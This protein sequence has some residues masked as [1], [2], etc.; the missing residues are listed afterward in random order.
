MVR[1]SA[2]GGTSVCAP[3]QACPDLA[4]RAP[5]CA[6]CVTPSSRAKVEEVGLLP[7]WAGGSPAP[8]VFRQR[9]WVAGAGGGVRPPTPGRALGRENRARSPA[10]LPD[11]DIGLTPSILPGGCGKWSYS[12]VPRTWEEHSV[13]PQEQE[14][15][16]AHTQP[17]RSLRFPR[18][19]C[20]HLGRDG[21][22]RPG[23]RAPGPRLPRGATGPLGRRR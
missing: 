12:V 14:S 18:G 6:L 10:Q 16:G 9:E 11:P 23:V 1:T 3:P 17:N 7:G 4:R 8:V 21:R 19:P 2:R 20:P 13:L 15:L 5:A 22:R